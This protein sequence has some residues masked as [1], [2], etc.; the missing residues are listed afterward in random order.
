MSPGSRGAAT[1]DNVECEI[2]FIGFQSGVYE[3][4][5]LTGDAEEQIM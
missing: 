5:S 2:F 1:A 3:N 4:Q